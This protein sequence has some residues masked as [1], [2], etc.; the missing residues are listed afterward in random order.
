MRHLLVWDGKCLQRTAGD[1]GGRRK[2]S[3]DDEDDTM[4]SVLVLAQDGQTAPLR[5]LPIFSTFRA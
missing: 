5:A 4:S 1:D 2:T 3:V